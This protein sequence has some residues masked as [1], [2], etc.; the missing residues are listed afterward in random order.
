MSIIKGGFLNLDESL[1][2]LDEFINETNI[3]QQTRYVVIF[4][5]F[6]DAKI[7][8]YKTIMKSSQDNVDRDIKTSIQTIND[9]GEAYAKQLEDIELDKKFQEGIE[10]AVHE[11]CSRQIVNNETPFTDRNKINNYILIIAELEAIKK[12]M[13]WDYIKG[14]LEKLKQLCEK[15]VIPEDLYSIAEC[16]IGKVINILVLEA[17]DINTYIPY[18]IIL[19]GDPGVGKSYNAQKLAEILK[20]SMLLAKG[21]VTTVTKDQIIGQYIGQTAPKTYKALTSNLEGVIFLDEAY[22]IPGAPSETGKKD[23]FGQEAMDCITDFTSVH[24][25]L[26]SIIAAGYSYEMEKSFLASNPGLDRRFDKSCRVDFKRYGAKSVVSILN[27]FYKQNFKDQG[28]QSLIYNQRALLYIYICSIYYMNLLFTLFNYVKGFDGIIGLVFSKNSKE[29]LNMF[30][31]FYKVV[32][33]LKDDGFEDL[34]K[35]L[36]N[37]NIITFP[38]EKHQCIFRYLTSGNWEKGKNIQIFN[39][40]LFNNIILK[41]SY[42]KDDK[43]CYLKIAEITYKKDGEGRVL[44]I[45]DLDDFNNIDFLSLTQN[46]TLDRF[47]I[48]FILSNTLKLQSGDFFKS[49]SADFG[50]Y[51]KDFCNIL[52]FKYLHY[53]KGDVDIATDVEGN[54]NE[55]SSASFKIGLE[56]FFKKKNIRNVKIDINKSSNKTEKKNKKDKKLEDNSF[57]DLEI[58]IPEQETYLSVNM[59]MNEK[60]EGDAKNIVVNA[61]QQI[62]ELIKSKEDLSN[63]DYRQF[64]LYELKAIGS[65]E[66][67]DQ[68]SK[69]DFPCGTY[70]FDQKI[71]TPG[72]S[73]SQDTELKEVNLEDTNTLNTLIRLQSNPEIDAFK[74]TEKQPEPQPD[75]SPPPLPAAPAST[76]N[77]VAPIIFGQPPAT[78]TVP[79][80][81]KGDNTTN[82][83]EKILKEKFPYS[84]HSV[85]NLDIAS[86]GD[87]SWI[88]RINDMMK[89]KNISGKIFDHQSHDAIDLMVNYFCPITAEY[90]KIGDNGLK[91]FTGK[92]DTVLY[93]TVLTSNFYMNYNVPQND[94]TPRHILFKYIIQ[95]QDGT[96]YVLYQIRKYTKET[97]YN[98]LNKGMLQDPWSPGRE[99]PY[100]NYYGTGSGT[101]QNVQNDLECI[102]NIIKE[103]GLDNDKW[104]A[105]LVTS[106]KGGKK[107]KK[108]IKFSKRKNKILKMKK[109]KTK[110]KN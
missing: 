11:A 106:N 81:G 95:E 107:K 4:Q 53:M 58:I 88:H 77:N 7:N 6:Y 89:P 33:N 52:S 67:F 91:M 12:K 39:E 74:G 79:T 85:R 59:M 49:Q 55:A 37:E 25:G 15:T 22:N 17:P 66:F 41:I 63:R 83:W 93:S 8:K 1:K 71:E 28:K 48:Y 103:Y 23:P 99:N 47:I 72:H 101:R 9:V 65:N 94:D 70:W 30:L 42:I 87:V 2:K 40:P 61:V 5:N 109:N 92:Y 44:S 35:K 10:T 31:Y 69:K 46:D 90:R 13:D 19:M 3:Q 108:Y 51:L 32:L 38:K 76:Y 97:I 60:G 86:R 43:K 21:K 62:K 45:N 68:I 100:V 110:R 57:K 75:T 73:I 18:N 82:I 80:P 20:Y 36:T 104:W 14:R 24:Q 16:V 50:N 105:Q 64:P 98:S 102:Y 56:E 78:S 96:Y 26:I 84:E 54:L 27:N 34:Q 29:Y